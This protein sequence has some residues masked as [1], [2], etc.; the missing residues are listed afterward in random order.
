MTLCLLQADADGDGYISCLQVLLTLKAIVPPELLSEE[1]EIYVYKVGFSLGVWPR[2][3][4]S[5]WLPSCLCLDV[6]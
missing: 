3:D 6:C 2:R 4:A 1:E 5:H